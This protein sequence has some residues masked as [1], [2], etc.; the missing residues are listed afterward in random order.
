MLQTPGCAQTA[1]GSGK[2]RSYWLSKIFLIPHKDKLCTLHTPH[3]APQHKNQL[4]ESAHPPTN[5][6]FPTN[7]AAFSTSEE[8]ARHYVGASV[9]VS[10]PSP[11]H[12]RFRGRLVAPPLL[13]F[14]T[15]LQS[16]R[17]AFYL[18]HQGMHFFRSEKCQ[19]MCENTAIN[20]SDSKSTF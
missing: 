16:G 12:R 18:T 1:R 19:T 14:R 4:L 8:Q 5:A 3:S 10:R 6:A 7:G 2:Y 17:R 9:E 20:I 11:T 15:R 13:M